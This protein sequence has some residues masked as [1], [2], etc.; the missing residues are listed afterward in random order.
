MGEVLQLSLVG[1]DFV[2]RKFR[3]S[4]NVCKGRLV[5]YG[6]RNRRGRHSA[7]N[8][9]DHGIGRRYVIQ[10]VA[11]VG[12]RTDDAVLGLTHHVV[13]RNHLVCLRDVIAGVNTVPLRVG[14][15]LGLEVLVQ[16]VLVG[17][18][19]LPGLHGVEPVEQAL[20]L[21]VGLLQF[22]FEFPNIRRINVVVVEALLLVG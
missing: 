13:L 10:G 11:G 1:R 15:V 5:V 3:S 22:S 6:E 20:C 19:P 12:Q 17:G 4:H 18:K 16:L 7:N 21:A 2:G 14:K 8:T 9:C